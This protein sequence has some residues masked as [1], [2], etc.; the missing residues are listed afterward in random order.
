MNK[1]ENIEKC[2]EIREKYLRLISDAKSKNRT[3]LYILTHE[4]GSRWRLA[5]Q[6][7]RD[8]AEKRVAD[9]YAAH[10]CEIEVASKALRTR[11]SE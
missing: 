1:Q 2:I 7:N 9:F 4:L 10:R 5:W 8:K 11:S 3:M 6:I